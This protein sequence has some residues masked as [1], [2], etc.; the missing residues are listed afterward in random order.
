MKNTTIK[1][2]ISKKK[3]SKKTS[4]AVS[5]VE[6]KK[7]KTPAPK[8]LTRSQKAWETMRE[9]YSEEEISERQREAAFKAW[10]TIR[11]RRAERESAVAQYFTT[12]KSGS[13]KKPSKKSGGKGATVRD[14]AVRPAIR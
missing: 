14:K 10:E 12:K 9:R 3:A 4:A 11:A 13:K 1:K 8:P 7:A 6:P 5:V 2:K